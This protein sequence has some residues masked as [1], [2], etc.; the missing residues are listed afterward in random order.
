M[1]QLKRPDYQPPQT[2]AGHIAQRGIRE[3]GHH[4]TATSLPHNGEAGGAETP[5]RAP[6]YRRRT[7]KGHCEKGLGPGRRDEMITDLLGN[8]EPLSLPVTKTTILYITRLELSLEN[9]G[10][11]VMRAKMACCD[12]A[13]SV[14]CQIW[15]FFLLSG[16]GRDPMT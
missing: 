5:L 16:E 15:T 6:S 2:L 12:A 13:G 7:V 8:T 3:H 9:C 11:L 1:P 14:G 10:T 4:V